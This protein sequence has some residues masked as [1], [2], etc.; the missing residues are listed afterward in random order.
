MFRKYAENINFDPAAP[1]GAYKG[2]EE[3][4]SIQ[5]LSQAAKEAGVWLVGGQS[6]TLAHVLLHA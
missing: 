6:V 3:C 2:S 1:K 4:P 5:M